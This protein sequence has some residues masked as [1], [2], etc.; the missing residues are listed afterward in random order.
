[1]TKPVYI[2]DKNELENYLLKNLPINYYHIG[3]LDDFF[4]PDTTWIA[5]KENGDIK[6][7][8]LLYKAEDPVVL[9]AI[10][11]NNPKELRDLLIASLPMMPKNL[12]CHLSPGLEEVFKQDYELEHHGEYNKMS[13]THPENLN[14][15]DTKNVEVL[16]KDD[17]AEIQL[18]YKASYPGNWFDPRMLETGQFVGMRDENAVLISIAGI[19]VYSADYKIAALGNITTRPDMRGQG[20]GTLVS[21]G[22]CKH[23][24]KTVDAIGLNVKSKNQAAIHAYQKIGFEKVTVYHEWTVTTPN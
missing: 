22:L 15:F 4:W 10:E 12:Y 2:T 11:N 7:L 9:L 8:L 6:A 21:A 23:L 13:L 24:L 5:S 19:H 1:M 3:D 14:R 16:R 17:L 20:L 18:L